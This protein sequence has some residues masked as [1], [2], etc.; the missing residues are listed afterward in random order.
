MGLLEEALQESLLL[1]G[2][3]MNT[4]LDRA[5]WVGLSIPHTW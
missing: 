2:T 3:S 4:N 1:A 5:P